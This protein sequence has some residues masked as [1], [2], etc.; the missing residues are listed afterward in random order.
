MFQ[1]IA[2]DVEILARFIHETFWKAFAWKMRGE[3]L[4]GY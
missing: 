4:R 3:H 2:E 1:E